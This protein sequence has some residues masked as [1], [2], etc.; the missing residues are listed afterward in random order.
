LNY[1]QDEMY[2]TKRNEDKKKKKILYDCICYF[3]YWCSCWMCIL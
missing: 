1:Y 2:I 3:F